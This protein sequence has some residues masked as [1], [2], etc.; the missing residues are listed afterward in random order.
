MRR[1]LPFHAIVREVRGRM[2]RG[3]LACA[4]CW[5]T[6]TWAETPVATESLFLEFHAPVGCPERNV[7]VEQVGVLTQAAEFDAIGTEPNVRR[8]SIRIRKEREQFAGELD[9]TEGAARA[10]RSFEADTCEEVVEALALATA[11]ALDPD[12]LSG[13]PPPSDPPPS[14]PAPSEKKTQE[15]S[16]KPPEEA[17][18]KDRPL[19]VD[20]ESREWAFVLG[21]SGDLGF[22]QARIPAQDSSLRRVGYVRPG[23][24]L[25]AEIETRAL[26]FRSSLDAGLGYATSTIDEVD[27]KWLPRARVGACPVWWVPADWLRVA[28]CARMSFGR[29]V[30][31]PSSSISQGQAATRSAAPVTHLLSRTQFLFGNF[32]VSVEVGAA[33]PLGENPYLLAAP[34]QD[35]PDETLLILTRHVHADLGIGFGWQLF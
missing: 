18:P 20:E 16:A 22:P 11:L 15:P 30:A 34:E 5:S 19:Y 9:L 2:V 17:K 25:Y 35:A 31:N 28:P 12:A 24:L 27:L 8:L 33:F 4:L 21:V 29:L 13:G 1:G 26:G 10:R 23:A 14:D 7:F 32:R 6:P 3:G